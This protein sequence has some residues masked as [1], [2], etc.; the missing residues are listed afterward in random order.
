MNQDDR[1][2]PAPHDVQQGRRG[3]ERGDEHDDVRP[4]LVGGGQDAVRGGFDGLLAGHGLV[5]YAGSVRA[6]GG[7]GRLA[8]ARGVVKLEA[9]VEVEG[10][11]LLAESAQRLG[12]PFEQVV[13]G[14]LG[15]GVADEPANR[16]PPG[17]LMSPSA[18]QPLARPAIACQPQGAE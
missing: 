14:E 11:D 18:L 6:G 1:V 15:S 17:V 4:A 3:E 16:P 9:A 7:F 2:A 8:D 12:P 13:D 5:E 10:V